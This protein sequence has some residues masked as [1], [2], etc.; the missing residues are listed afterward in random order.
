MAFI[1][2]L[3]GVGVPM[4]DLLLRQM[5]DMARL[6]GGDEKK[7][8][9]S[10]RL[11]REVL[12]LLTEDLN[13]AAVE[14]RLRELQE[15]ARREMTPNE[16]AKAA[17]IETAIAMGLA[18]IRSPWQR[19]AVR[20]DPAPALRA[21]KCPVLAINGEKDCQVAA[22]ENVEGMARELAAGG[23]KNVK[24]AILP[25]L[26]HL[27]QTCQT[28]ELKEYGEIEETMSPAVLTMVA[29]WILK[30]GAK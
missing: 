11:G 30:V 17:P 14:K 23:N 9:L 18:R 21:V 12:R 1:V 16:I 13:D 6:E 15:E 10:I 19:W 29:D 26:N 5:E 28:G 24:T 25:N 22:K 20:Y 2:L 27:F 4:K 7:A 8:A 3:A